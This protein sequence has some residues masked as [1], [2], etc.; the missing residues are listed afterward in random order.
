MLTWGTGKRA[1]GHRVGFG[2]CNP[3]AALKVTLPIVLCWPTMSEADD[4]M[5]VEVESSPHLATSGVTTTSQNQNGSL[6]SCD[7]QTPHPSKSSR[8]SPQHD[9][10]C[11][12][13]S[14]IRKGRSFC[15]SWNLGKSSTLTPA[16][17][18]WLKWR[19][20][21]PESGKRRWKPGFCKM[22]TPGLIPVWRL[23]STL[24]ISAGLSYHTLHS[25][26]LASSN[27]NL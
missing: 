21:L 18:C 23:W 8:G 10:S 14:E 20:K 1:E 16:L 7:M 2:I 27:T 4:G 6:Q 3:K 19:L 26:D 15:I 24:P 12:L 13:S 25:P 17:W 5:A 11:T 22:I 9:K